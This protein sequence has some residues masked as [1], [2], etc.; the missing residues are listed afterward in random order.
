MSPIIAYE[1]S[2]FDIILRQLIQILAILFVK[3]HG[4]VVNLTR[5]HTFL[6][7]SVNILVAHRDAFQQQSMLKIL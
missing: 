1:N 7:F 5:K 6:N 4:L 3:L 2:C